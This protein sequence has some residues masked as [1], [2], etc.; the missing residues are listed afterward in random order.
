MKKRIACKAA[1]YLFYLQSVDGPIQDPSHQGE[2]QDAFSLMQRLG[3]RDPRLFP[4][5]FSGLPWRVWQ[6]IQGWGP[7][8]NRA[9]TFRVQSLELHTDGSAILSNGWPIRPLQAGWGFAVFARGVEGQWAF[10]GAAW[11]PVVVSQELPFFIG[12]QQ[13]TIPVAELSAITQALLW[14]HSM[15]GRQFVRARHHIRR[16]GSIH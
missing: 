1:L 14:Y 2:V 4:S 5:E 3:L 12:A 7:C 9:T 13:P 11:G 10:L 6:A 15:D 16:H 8:P